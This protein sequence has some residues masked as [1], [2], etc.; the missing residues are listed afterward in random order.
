MLNNEQ[1]RLLRAKTVESGLSDFHKMWFLLIKQASKSKK[2]K[3][4]HIVTINVLK[5][6]N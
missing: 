1:E 4:S 2:P 3:M 6:K 5:M